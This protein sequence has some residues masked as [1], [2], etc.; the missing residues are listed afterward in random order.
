MPSS[1]QSSQFIC[2]EG[3]VGVPNTMI[4]EERQHVS[5]WLSNPWRFSF[6]TLTPRDLLEPLRSSRKGAQQPRRRHGMCLWARFGHN[7]RRHQIRPLC[8]RVRIHHIWL[9]LTEGNCRLRSAHHLHDPGEVIPS[10]KVTDKY[11]IF[12]VLRPFL[13]NLIYHPNLQSHCK[14][15]SLVF[16]TR[17]V[18]LIQIPGHVGL[19]IHLCCCGRTY[20]RRQCR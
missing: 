5:L 4:A 6:T 15:S 10:R 11:F 13:S 16:R 1:C 7:E 12:S 8:S 9:Q 3:L 17:Y 18:A 2:L 20:C 19:G 14:N